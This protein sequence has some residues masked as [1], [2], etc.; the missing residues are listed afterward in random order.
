MRA[1]LEAAGVRP[2][3]GEV[4]ALARAYPGLRRQMEALYR[5]PTGDDAPATMLHAE[6]GREH[7]GTDPRHGRPR[8]DELRFAP[9]LDQA[10]ALRD[11]STSSVELVAELRRRPIG[12]TPAS[13]PTW[14][15]STSRRGEAAAA[16]DEARARG[17][18]PASC[19]ASPSA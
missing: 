15:A 10:A 11:G 19:T 17:D 9:L 12:S 14:S 18:G 7:A 1:L 8:A 16:A 6:L 3:E 2:S 5:V 13:A 4:G